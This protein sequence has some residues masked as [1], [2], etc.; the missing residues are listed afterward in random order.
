MFRPINT[1]FWVLILTSSWGKFR[2]NVTTVKNNFKYK[3]TYLNWG[4]LK[5]K[6]GT[7]T[8]EKKFG[9]KTGNT[10][11]KAGADVFAGR[12]KGEGEGEANRKQGF[13]LDFNK[14]KGSLKKKAA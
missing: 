5:Y 10:N 14:E 13:S 6:S 9:V 2:A 11:S 12:R 3:W 7:Q 8:Y 4:T 1:K